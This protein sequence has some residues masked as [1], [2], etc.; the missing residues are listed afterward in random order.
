MDHALITLWPHTLLYAYLPLLLILRA[1]L[2]LCQERARVILIAP[3]WS[4]QVWYLNLLHLSVAFLSHFLSR[5]LSCRRLWDSDPSQ[6]LLEPESM[7]PRWFPSMELTCSGK[8]QLVFLCSR[9][10]NFHK[11]YPQ[12]WKCFHSWCSFHSSQASEIPPD[13]LLDLKT[14]GLSMNSESIHLV[15]VTTF[16]SLIKASQL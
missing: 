4:R 15:A 8:V 2:K 1:L 11:T 12:K 3:F 16:H 10:A 13:C 7:V 9:K 14:R 6:P 5:R